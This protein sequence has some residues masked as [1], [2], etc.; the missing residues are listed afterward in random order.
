MAKRDDTIE[1]LSAIGVPFSEDATLDE[2]TALLAWAEEKNVAS[3]SSAFDLGLQMPEGEDPERWDRWIAFLQKA[4]NQ[5]S[6]IKAP[7]GVS[8]RDV[9]DSHLRGGV[10]AVVVGGITQEGPLKPQFN[11][12]PRDFK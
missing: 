5:R 2:L 4:R 10:E 7:N 8:P 1:K 9:F 6:P 3:V 12:I 11:T